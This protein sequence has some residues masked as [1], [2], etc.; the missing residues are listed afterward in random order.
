[1]DCLDSLDKIFSFIDGRIKDKEH[2]EELEEHL[3]H[4]KR[5][6]D[7]VEFE[8]R[9]QSFIQE[10]LIKEEIPVEVTDRARNMLNRFRKY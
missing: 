6:Y 4:C 10:S 1:M 8:K 5:C 3:R 9:I 7:V 2:L